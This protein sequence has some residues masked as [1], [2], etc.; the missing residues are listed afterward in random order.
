MRFFLLF[1]GMMACSGSERLEPRKGSPQ[2]LVTQTPQAR[3]AFYASQCQALGLA[4]G[5]EGFK[6]CVEEQSAR[7][8]L[9]K[10]RNDFYRAALED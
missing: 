8:Q 9:A 7:F 10:I 3:A 6:E 2:W 1:L 4:P 5:A